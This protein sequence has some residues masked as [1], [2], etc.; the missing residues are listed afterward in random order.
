MKLFAFTYLLVAT[1]LLTGCQSFQFVENPIPVNPTPI[2]L[3]AQ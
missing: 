3:A 1:L 2:K